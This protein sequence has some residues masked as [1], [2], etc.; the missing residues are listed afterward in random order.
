[1]IA[2]PR[3]FALGVAGSDGFSLSNS[4]FNSKQ[5]GY[6]AKRRDKC[7]SHICYEITISLPSST[8]LFEADMATIPWKPIT[9]FPN[10]LEV[11]PHL[12]ALTIECK[13]HIRHI[14]FLLCKR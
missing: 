1:L 7:E 4:C 3:G 12:T 6:M 10:N 13:V 9:Y 5:N 11:V 14:S 8:I 2:S